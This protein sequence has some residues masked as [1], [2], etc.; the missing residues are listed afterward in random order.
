MTS[1]RWWTVGIDWIDL[2]YWP[3]TLMFLSFGIIGFMIAPI[4]NWQLLPLG[5]LVLFLG[6]GVL[7][8]CFDELKGRPLGT[9]IPEDHLKAV[10][11]SSI[12]TL[13]VVTLALTLTYSYFILPLF[14]LSGSIVIVYN[15]ELFSGRFHNDMIFILGFGIMPQ[16][17]A[18][19]VS[20]LVFPSLSII[21]I[22]IALSSVC[23]VE[24]TVNHWVKW[25]SDYQYSYDNKFAYLQRAVWS[26]VFMPSVLAL[27]LTLW[28]LGY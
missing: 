1:K 28:R 18:Y 13:S 6:V 7:A 23:G 3:Y 24:T 17:L 20:S 26:A 5:L 11:I 9:N 2:M 16:F 10:I 15:L 21:I 27:G 25:N 8:H 12:I 19:F 4:Q 22:M 14:L